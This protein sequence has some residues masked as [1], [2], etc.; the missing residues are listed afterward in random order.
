[1]LDQLI[2]NINFLFRTNLVVCIITFAAGD[3]QTFIIRLQPVIL[4]LGKSS[5]KWGLYQRP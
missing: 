4:K 1:M 2:K 3:A 5:F